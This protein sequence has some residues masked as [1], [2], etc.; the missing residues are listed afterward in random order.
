MWA[1]FLPDK[2]INKIYPSERVDPSIRIVHTV[3]LICI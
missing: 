2:H 1:I 3:H